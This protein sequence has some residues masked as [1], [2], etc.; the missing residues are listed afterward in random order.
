MSKV[1]VNRVLSEKIF[2][3]LPRVLHRDILHDILLTPIHNANETQLERVCPSS[4]HV[5]RIGTRVHEVNFA[6]YP[7]STLTTR[8]DGPGEFERV[9]VG[10]IY[11]GWGN[12]ENDTDEESENDGR[13]RS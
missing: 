13:F 3:L 12:S 2:F 4:E 6:Q 8:I 11:V 5:E 10:E 1:P 7:K 9:G